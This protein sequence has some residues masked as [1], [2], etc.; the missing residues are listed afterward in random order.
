MDLCVCLL[1]NDVSSSVSGHS[2]QLLAQVVLT[3]S[4]ASQVTRDTIRIGLQRVYT[5][6]ILTQILSRL[7]VDCA[8]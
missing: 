1:P 8:P 4:Q 5:L 3:E 6:Y 7:E 2:L